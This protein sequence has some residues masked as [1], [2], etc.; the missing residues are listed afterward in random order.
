M[1]SDVPRVLYLIFTLLLVLDFKSS[2]SREHS[3]SA[4]D[5]LILGHAQTF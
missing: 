1:S 5:D 2:T 4:N 3:C